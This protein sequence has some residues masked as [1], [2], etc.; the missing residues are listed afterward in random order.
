MSSLL[1]VKGGGGGGGAKSYDG[2]K[3]LSYIN[4]SIL[5][6]ITMTGAFKDTHF[7]KTM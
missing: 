2:E 4:H 6:N 1:T 7:R 5:L 3:A